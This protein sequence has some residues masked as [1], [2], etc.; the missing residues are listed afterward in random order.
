MPK[1]V[2][3]AALLFLFLASVEPAASQDACL[4]AVSGE[5]TVFYPEG[6]EKLA[7]RSL[8]A[9]KSVK[10]ATGWLSASFPL[11]VR[12]Y[13][14]KD[15][16]EFFSRQG[17]AKKK[18]AIGFASYPS[19]IVMQTPDNIPD[20]YFNFEKTLYH[21]YAHL[22]LFRLN[23]GAPYWLNEGFT[24]HISGEYGMYESLSLYAASVSGKLPSFRSLEEDF[25]GDAS[26]AALAYIVSTSMVS[27]MIDKIG[28]DKFKEFYGRASAGGIDALAPEYFSG[29]TWEELLS[30][31]ETHTL[32]Y[33]NIL[34]FTSSAFLFF[35]TSLLFLAAYIVKKRKAK[36]LLEAMEEDEYRIIYYK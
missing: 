34:F 29:M 22:I 9:L 33:R 13:L 12:I 16:K 35:V 11:K 14:V 21:E 4:A 26:Y 15:R 30:S 5:I 2:L 23:R 36:K 19:E 25:P 17:G 6:M 7:G 3:A 32:R 27:F 28:R 20:R 31:W 24:R 8:L 10:S 1:T 18:W